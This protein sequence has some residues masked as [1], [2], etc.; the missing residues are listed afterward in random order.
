LEEEKSADQL[1]TT[2]AE[3]SVNYQATEEVED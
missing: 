2:V 1:L 3:D